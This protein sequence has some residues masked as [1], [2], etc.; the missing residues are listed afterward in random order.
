MTRLRITLAGLALLAATLLPAHNA[1][2]RAFCH[3]WLL[4]RGQP[5]ACTPHTNVRP[6]DWW[7]HFPNTLH[8]HR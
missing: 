2:A 7:W 4:H 5:V 1:Q 6:G 8:T 3:A